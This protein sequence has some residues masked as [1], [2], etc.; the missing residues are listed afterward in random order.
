MTSIKL[1][2]AAIC[3]W[4]AAC[5]PPPPTQLYVLNSPV[6]RPGDQVL[7]LAPAPDSKAVRSPSTAPKNATSLLIGVAVTV[8]EYLDRLEIVQRSSPNEIKPAYSALWGENLTIA[9]TRAM[10]ENLTVQLPTDDVITLPSRSTKSFDYQVNLDLYR[11]ETDP[12]GMSI[13][14]GRWSITDMEGTERASGRVAHSEPIGGTGYAAV[15]AAMSR[16]LAAVS[17]E[18]STAI[19]A[20]PLRRKL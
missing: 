16:N 2:Q 15:A 20:A 1:C 11:F 19:R 17:E 10:V 9:A 3:L 14:T 18:I 5:A 4:L 7:S 13:L 6:A 12:S 8:P